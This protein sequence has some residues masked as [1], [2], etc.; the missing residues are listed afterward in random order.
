MREPSSVE[1]T[2]GPG[3]VAGPFSLLLSFITLDLSLKRGYV[4]VLSLQGHLFLQI[5]ESID[6]KKNIMI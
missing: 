5:V 1:S 3:G 6:G 4:E 2:R